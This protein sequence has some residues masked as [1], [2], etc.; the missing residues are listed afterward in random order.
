VARNE[1]PHR[2]HEDGETTSRIPP[3]GRGL[4]DVR[5]PLPE[6]IRD[7]SFPAAVR[8]YDRRAVDSYV[9]RVNG[10]IAELQ[11]SGSPPAAVR[12]ALDRVGEQTSGILQHARET[13]EE[14]TKSAR[15]EA[16]E[17]TARAKA[18]AQDITT[19]AQ[20]QASEAIARASNEADELVARAR[21]EADQIL[22]RANEQSEH[23]LAQARVEAEERTRLVEQEIASLREDAEARIRS[24][25]A[26]IAAISNERRT[27]LDDVRRMA[28]H[29]EAIVAEPEPA[30]DTPPETPETPEPPAAVTNDATPPA[31]PNG[32]DAQHQQ[33]HATRSSPET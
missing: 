19:G 13:A 15:E 24:L 27:L 4:R 31:G 8:G 29:L 6:D 33:R 21:T 26:D 20:G 25:Q 3:E 17:T 5:D 1:P 30:E 11:V 28:A 22:A 14:I 23:T 16:E 2:T 32:A 10:L 7:P 9:E 18:E 12:H